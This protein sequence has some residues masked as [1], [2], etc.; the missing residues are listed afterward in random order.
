MWGD[1]KWE[2]VSYRVRPAEMW[3]K[4]DHEHGL[5]ASVTGVKGWYRWA[6]YNGNHLLMGPSQP[7]RKG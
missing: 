1:L 5:H 3:V 7:R 4:R 2:D 6:V